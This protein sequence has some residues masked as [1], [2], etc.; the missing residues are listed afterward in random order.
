MIYLMLL[1]KS[2]AVYHPYHDQKEYETI[3]ENVIPINEESSIKIIEHD[4]REN[5]I[6]MAFK[7]LYASVYFYI[8]LG[9][10]IY[11]G[12]SDLWH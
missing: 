4:I 9:L 2:R 11:L 6:R 10:F 5:N 3:V 8:L 1:F 12:G 7:K